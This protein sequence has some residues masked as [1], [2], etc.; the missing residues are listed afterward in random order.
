MA[1]WVGRSGELR[2][3]RAVPLSRYRRVADLWNWLPAFRAAAEYE[4]IQRAALA[5]N[6][7]ASA[8][9]RTV[10]LLEDA[11]GLP[12][13]LRSPTGLTLTAVGEDL[14]Q[15]TRHAMRT[16][17]ESL[18]TSQ[19]APNPSFILAAC[20]PALPIVLARCVSAQPA[21]WREASVRMRTLAAA[22]VRDLLLRGEIDFALM[23]DAPSVPDVCRVA[24]GQLQLSCW[25][26]SDAVAE[27]TIEIAFTDV[28]AQPGRDGDRRLFIDELGAGIELA[29]ASRLRVRCP[30]VLAPHDFVEQEGVRTALDVFVV[31]RHALPG[32]D[33]GLL[34]ALTASV[35]AMLQSA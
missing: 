29:R 32:Q 24:V 11:V 6:M 5:L 34:D 7:S 17:D 28:D 21:I 2:Y 19:P 23:V 20:G 26:P 15:A 14:L 10:R 12:L 25:G 35:R 4:S 22:H 33:R 16:I 31:M 8:L 9:S 27:P 1:R 13:F 30:N 3:H 18:H